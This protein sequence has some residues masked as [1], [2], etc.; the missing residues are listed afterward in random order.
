MK[1]QQMNQKQFF[2]TIPKEIINL[3]KLKK[4]DALEV[5]YLETNDSLMIRRGD[6]K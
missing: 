6:K 5:T 1:L 4:G 3:M 2:V